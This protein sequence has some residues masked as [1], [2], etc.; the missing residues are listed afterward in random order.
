MLRRVGI[1]DP[2]RA[3][4]PLPAPVLG[5]AE[6]A[7]RDRHGA[8]ARPGRHRRRRADDGARRHGAGRDPRPAAHAAA[9]SSA[10]RSSSSPTTW[11]SSPTSPTGW[12]S[13][14]RARSSRRP[15]SQ[16][17]FAVTAARLHQ[18]AARRRAA[19]ARAS[20]DGRP[21]R[22][23]PRGVG[24]RDPVVAATGLVIEYPGRFGRPAFRAVDRVELRDRARRGARPG[25]RVRLGQDHDRPR[26]RRASP[27][28]PAARCRVLGAE[29]LGMQRARVPPAR[30][31]R[32]GLRLPGPGDELQPAAHDR[33][34]ASPSR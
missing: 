12:R 25:R 17:L 29:M 1:P 16:T 34:S 27:R 14:T 30:A 5:R 33:R 20:R 23:T 26:D 7:H 32:I 24:R 13:C 9:T 11:A 4:R 21:G 31:S 18:D 19:S 28:S 6:A 22:G 3:R 10:P 8:R 15:T 2:E